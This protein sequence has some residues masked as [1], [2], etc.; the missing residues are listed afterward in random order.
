MDIFNIFKKKPQPRYT[1]DYIKIV[2]NR[3]T[4]NT[5]DVHI[6][7]ME[8]GISIVL[9]QYGS[10]HSND[11]YIDIYNEYNANYWVYDLFPEL[12]KC[13]APRLIY[14][15]GLT[16]PDHIYSYYF[17]IRDYQYQLLPDRLKLPEKLEEF[18]IDIF[19]RTSGYRTR[20]AKEAIDKTEYID[21]IRAHYLAMWK[22]IIY[23][24]DFKTP[25]DLLILNE[26]NWLTSLATK[27]GEI[28]TRNVIQ[29]TMEEYASNL[30]IKNP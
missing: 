4:I 22:Y 16:I 8:K 7:Q 2:N 18:L 21:M 5:T 1:K 9:K 3:I 25:I 6:H 14:N 26:T 15:R 23:D 10:K 27:D 11:I 13:V 19:E 20:G 30:G 29:R 28:A 17:L 12:L 24:D